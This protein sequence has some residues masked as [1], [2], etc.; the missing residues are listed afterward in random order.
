MTY[1][2]EFQANLII[3]AEGE[4]EEDARTAAM[5]ELYARE[6]NESIFW[7]EVSVGKW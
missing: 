4:T 7:K 2:F 1:Q 6:A 3:D 5:D